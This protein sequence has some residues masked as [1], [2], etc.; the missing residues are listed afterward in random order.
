MQENKKYL[1]TCHN[2]QF[3][4]LK[5]QIQ[6]AHL[7]SKLRIITCKYFPL[8]ST[9]NY[10]CSSTIKDAEI[11]NKKLKILK[12][13]THF[14]V[15]FIY[16][17]TTKPTKTDT[18]THLYLFRL[19]ISFKK[20]H[21][22][23][24]I[25]KVKLL[26]SCFM[27]SKQTC[28]IMGNCPKFVVSLIT[29]PS[30]YWKQ[31]STVSFPVY[32]IFACLHCSEK[33]NQKN[34]INHSIKNNN[35]NKILHNMKYEILRLKLASNGSKASRMVLENRSFCGGYSTGFSNASKNQVKRTNTNPIIISIWT[36]VNANPSTRLNYSIIILKKSGKFRFSKKESS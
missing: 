2:K 35:N 5:W 19:T 22:K 8:S 13:K 26:I 25:Y 1:H 10:F 32:E 4:T 34:W 36:Q 29:G 30:L 15:L 16:R 14:T 18:S 28:N 6:T 11:K 33:K 12:K 21:N 3:H 20:E 23:N 24:Q 31:T 17:Q 27:R 7:K 9:Q